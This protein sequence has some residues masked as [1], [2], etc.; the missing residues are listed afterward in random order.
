MV[1]GDEADFQRAQ[2]YFDIM[3]NSAILIGGVGS[4]SITKLANQI[5]VNLGIAAVSEAFVLASKA[6]ADPEKVYQAIR[7]GLAGK[8]SSGRE[9]AN[10]VLPQLYAGRQN[11]H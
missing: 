11:L 2:P 9:G 4:G 3:G 8:H 7:G 6:G 5:I 1:G 10:D